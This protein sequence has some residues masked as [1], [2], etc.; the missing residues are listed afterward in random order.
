MS[1]QIK[2]NT[3]DLDLNI[4]EYQPRPNIDNL[5]KNIMTERRREKKKTIATSI[6]ILSGVTI[7]SLW[8]L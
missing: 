2:K 1:S 6:L 3:T 7:I 8:F 5:I 4:K